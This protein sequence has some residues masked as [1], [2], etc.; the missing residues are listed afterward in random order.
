MV[1][2]ISKLCIS[3]V[4]VSKIIT[5]Y[6]THVKAPLRMKYANILILE[7]IFSYIAS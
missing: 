5:K 1:I 3:T 6:Q 7:M 2:N 4:I